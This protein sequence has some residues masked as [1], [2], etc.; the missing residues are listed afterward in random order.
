MLR[1]D[2][3]SK[4]YPVGETEVA[5]LKS[6]SFAIEAGEVV[7][8]LG[9]SGSGK[10]TLLHLAAGLERP[11]EGSVSLSG[12]SLAE[13]SEREMSAVR[14][15]DVGF[16]FQLFHLVQGLTAV[17]NVAL[18]LRFNGHSRRDASAR[19]RELLEQV[20]LGDRLEHYPPQLSGGE[21]QRVGLA[22]ALAP[23][24]RLLLA[25]EPTGSLDAENGKLLLELTRKIAKE[26]GGAVVLV[27]HDER[28]IPYGDRTLVLNDGR[29]V[30]GGE[31]RQGGTLVETG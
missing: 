10:T 19:A 20:G 4:R 28:A 21:M 13:L 2:G 16:V 30:A 5:A 8:V 17:E 14:R 22:R 7:V 12:Q 3:V 25:D 29:L 9:P 26:Q 31:T 23:R 11:S 27:T 1:F 24:P 6:V 18:P 15:S